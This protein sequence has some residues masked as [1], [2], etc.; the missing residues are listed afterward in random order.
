MNKQFKQNRN[1]IVRINVLTHTTQK[2]IVGE[3]STPENV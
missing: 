3:E 1:L 2:L